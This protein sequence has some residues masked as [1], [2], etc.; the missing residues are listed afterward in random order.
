MGSDSSEKEKADVLRSC[1]ERIRQLEEENQK[2]RE[3]SSTFGQLAERLN[4]NLSEER[5]LSVADRRSRPR[6]TPSRRLREYTVQ[7]PLHAS[8]DAG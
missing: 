6:P 1:Q 4:F 7:P 2:L 3:A 8:N 5:R